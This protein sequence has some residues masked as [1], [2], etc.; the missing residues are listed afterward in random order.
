MIRILLADDHPIVREGLRAVL[1]TQPDFEVI[2][3]PEQAARSCAE[4]ELR[5]R[6]D[7]LNAR[8][9]IAD[10]SDDG[11]TIEVPATISELRKSDP[12]EAREIQKTIGERFHKLFDM[13]LAVIGFER[14]EEAGTYL[15]GFW[16]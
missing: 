8:E 15:L 10:L 2:G 13:G 12:K 11:A 7:V 14:S 3:T 16:K 5:V 4:T 6:D 9:R 1:E